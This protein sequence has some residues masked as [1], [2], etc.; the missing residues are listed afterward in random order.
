MDFTMNNNTTAIDGRA[1]APDRLAKLIRLIFSTDKEGEIVA[2]VTA[3]KRI[4]ISETLDAHFVADNFLR[5]A[6]S[7]MLPTPDKRDECD[8]RSAAWFCYHNRKR[9]SPKEQAFVENIVERTAPLSPK[10]RKW[11]CDIVDRL[12]SE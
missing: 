12:E 7:I 10:Q 9:L 5:G 4:L 3:A 11:L 1:V 8:D 6:T 2:A